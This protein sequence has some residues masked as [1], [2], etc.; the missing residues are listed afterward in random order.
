M[1]TFLGFSMMVVFLYLIMSKRLSA[2]NALIIVPVVFAL[3]GGFTD[4]G[5]M[6][7]KGVETIAPT[8]VMV[9]FAILY[10]GI[11]IDAG[12][13]DPL[14]NRMIK[15]AKGDP[16]KI[17]LATAILSLMVGLDG[18]GTITYLIVV[19]AFLPIYERL[20]MNKL[21]LACLPA[22]AMGIM[23][24]LPWGGPTSRLMTIFNYDALELLQPLIPSILVGASY[25]IGL[26]VFFGLKER[27][28]LGIESIK[29]ESYKQIAATLDTTP[30]NLKRPHLFW[31]N[32]LTTLLLIVGLLTNVLPLPAL[33]MIGFVIVNTVNYPKLKDQKERLE[34]H[35]GNILTVTSLIFAGG[36]FAGILEGTEM[37]DA[38]ASDLVHIIPDFL[39]PQLPSIVALTSMPFTFLMANDPYYF[40]I[41]PIL[42]E[43]ATGFGLSKLEIAQA[44]LLGQPLHLLS[45]LVGSVYVLIGLIGI[46]FRDH[47]RFSTKYAIGTSLVMILTAIAFGVLSI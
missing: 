47:I 22:M 17:T 3:L 34:A 33:F 45:P 12:M 5:P 42:A 6:M 10:F 36:I 28:R 21:I 19:T 8:A 13:F 7:M 1:L 14:V 35:A 2:I 23:N 41:I 18:D 11:L 29:S 25:I 26:G 20:G 24:L 32:V 37:V 31:F 43:T 16:L 46:D 4:L 40:G 39:G 44:S 15:I 27:K 38:I 30:Q 9:T